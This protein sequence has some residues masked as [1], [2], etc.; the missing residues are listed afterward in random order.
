[1][2]ITWFLQNSPAADARLVAPEFNE[3]PFRGLALTLFASDESLIW[4]CKYYRQRG[5]WVPAPV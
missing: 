4:Y 1:M 3:H 2:L 5:Q